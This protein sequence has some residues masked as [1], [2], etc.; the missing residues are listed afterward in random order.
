MYCNM[1]GITKE[2]D[3]EEHDWNIEECDHCRRNCSSFID[4]SF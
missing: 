4:F 1:E 3:I 2:E